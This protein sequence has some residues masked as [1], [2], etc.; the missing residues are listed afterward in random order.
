MLGKSPIKQP[1]EVFNE[2]TYEK[3]LETQYPRYQQ[4]KRAKEL[5][6]IQVEYGRRL[7]IYLTS[8]CPFCG[9]P[10]SE[11]IDTFSLNGFGWGLANYGAGWSADLGLPPKT[12]GKC[13]HLR[14]ISYFLNLRGQVPVELFSD[15][16]IKAGPEVPSIMRVPM[17]A[18]DAIAVI[19]ELP[20]GRYGE[21]PRQPRYSV[22]FVSYFTERSESFAEAT[23]D[24]GVHYGSVEY[25]DVDYDL[26][27]WAEGK[28]LLWL[29]N[30]HPELPLVS[31]ADADFP[32][33]DI[34]GDHSPERIIT[35]TGVSVPQPDIISRIMRFFQRGKK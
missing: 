13:R 34:E 29:D 28:R 31:I 10:K 4:E 5:V 2:H 26:V 1:D 20:V 21:H 24:W 19:H 35:C 32:Y 9:E 15:K 25:D 8:R 16:Q 30:N 23:K 3:F 18:S 11:P 17:A 12:P 27:S 33:A 22:Y 6:K 14:I 7:P